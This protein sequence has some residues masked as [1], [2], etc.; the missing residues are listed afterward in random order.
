MISEIK[1]RHAVPFALGDVTFIA[2]HVHAPEGVP[3]SFSLFVVAD[4]EHKYTLGI[5][6]T[7]PVRGETWALDRVEN[8]PDSGR[9]VVLTK[10]N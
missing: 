7:F 8:L 4:G 6:D 1:L 2:G 9:W 5:G 10:V 3:L